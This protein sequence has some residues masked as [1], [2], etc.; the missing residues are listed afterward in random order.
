MLKSSDKFA[1]TTNIKIDID[2]LDDALRSLHISGSV[3]LREAYSSPCAISIPGAERLG[4]LLK[5]KTG[6]SVV[7]FHLLQF[8]HCEIKPKSGTALTL[9]AGDMIICFG[10]EA[11][12]LSQGKIRQIQ[13][14]ETLLAGDVNTQR[15][16]ITGTA[17]VVS[18]ICGVFM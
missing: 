3:L 16:D 6:T 17:P 7:A 4:S 13:P 8:G 15:P 1:K 14:I 5:V 2:V 11:H 9:T 18:L 12:Q 10:G